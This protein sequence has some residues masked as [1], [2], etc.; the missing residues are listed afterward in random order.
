MAQV[1][2]VGP[3]GKHLGSPGFGGDLGFELAFVF[4]AVSY[5]G[6]RTVEKK[7]FGR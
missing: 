2:F 3:V 6:F 4:S 5:I 7:H 1:W